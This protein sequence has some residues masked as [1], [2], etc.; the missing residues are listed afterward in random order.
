M[1][2]LQL[3]YGIPSEDELARLMG[4]ATPH[5][6][7]QIRDRVRAYADALPEEHPRRIMLAAQVTRLEALAVDGE[8]GPAGDIDLPPCLS[9]DVE[10]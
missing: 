8:R 9:L 2:I 7:L 10:R 3:D 5:F 6:A 4:A 1:T